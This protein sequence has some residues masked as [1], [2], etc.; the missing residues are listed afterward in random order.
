MPTE[1]VEPTRQKEEPLTLSG[2]E[3]LYSSLKLLSLLSKL[4]LYLIKHHTMMT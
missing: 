3:P 2:T 1:P 4:F